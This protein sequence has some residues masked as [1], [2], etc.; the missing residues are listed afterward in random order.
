M[1]YH[2]GIIYASGLVASSAIYAVA[3]NQF[4]VVGWHT[5]MK[6]RVAVC[7]IIYRKVNKMEISRL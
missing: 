7:S 1:D 3:L 2:E 5:G 4:V 6:V